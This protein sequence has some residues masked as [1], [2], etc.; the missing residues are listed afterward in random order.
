[1]KSAL[2][3]LSVTL[4]G[5][6][7]RLTLPQIRTT[8]PGPSRFGPI[9]VGA[10]PLTLKEWRELLKDVGFSVRTT[11]EARMLLLEPRRM[12]HNEGLWG[13]I[14]FVSR[15]IASPSARR[16]IWGIGQTFKHYS[17]CIGAAAL[18]AVKPT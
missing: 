6:S 12:F 8:P 14:R 17:N 7:M 5:S 16:R 3:A 15:V 4:G 10:R 2:V 9:R 11:I 13:G 1:V 18:I